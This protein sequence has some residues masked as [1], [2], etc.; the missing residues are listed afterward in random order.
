MHEPNYTCSLKI[1]VGLHNKNWSVLKV[2]SNWKRLKQAFSTSLL[3]VPKQ[4]F[5]KVEVPTCM[6]GDCVARERSDRGDRWGQGAK[7]PEASRF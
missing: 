5:I 1:Y 7:P 2:E 6:F 4:N 3:E